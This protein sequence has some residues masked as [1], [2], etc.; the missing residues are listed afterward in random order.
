M[1]IVLSA[2]LENLSTRNDGSIK[3]VFA[4]QEMDSAMAGQVFQFRN[5]FCKVLI[6]DSNITPLEEKL[7]DEENVQDGKKI[8]TQSQRLRAVLFRLHEQTSP[9]IDFDTWYKEKMESIIE[10]YK[11]KLE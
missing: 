4:T 10:H 11:T 1:K 6:S 5:K 3:L 7:I 8:K 9:Q 2:V